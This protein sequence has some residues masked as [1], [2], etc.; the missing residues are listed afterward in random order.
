M[1]P[2]QYTKEQRKDIETRVDKAKIVLA[3]LKLQPACMPMMEN[4]GDD[5]FGVKLIP[6]L[7]DTKYQSVLSPIQP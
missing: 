5:V 4:T 2:D 7:Q 1:N 3:E 6:F